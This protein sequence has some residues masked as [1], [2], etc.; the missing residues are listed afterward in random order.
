MWATMMQ[1]SMLPYVVILRMQTVQ[2]MSLGW[3]SVRGFV[4]LL[5]A[6]CYIM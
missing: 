4:L 2:V 6:H 5:M 3:Y 1:V